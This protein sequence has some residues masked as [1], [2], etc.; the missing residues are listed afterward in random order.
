[1]GSASI[2]ALTSYFRYIYTCPP[3][4][5]QELPQKQENLV[6]AHFRCSYTYPFETGKNSNKNQTWWPLIR[7][8]S[9]VALNSILDI[10]IAL[11][12]KTEKPQKRKTW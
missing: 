8:D 9:I 12:P 2:A 10:Q 3:H 11:F 4:T 7:S 5:K 1:M 6:V